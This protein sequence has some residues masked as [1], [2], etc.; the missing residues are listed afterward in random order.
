MAEADAEAEV[1]VEVVDVGAEYD[2]M[3]PSEIVW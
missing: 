1:G 2:P 3:L